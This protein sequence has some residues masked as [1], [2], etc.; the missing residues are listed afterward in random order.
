M[1]PVSNFGHSRTRMDDVEQS[2]HQSEGVENPAELNRFQSVPKI[3]QSS[4]QLAASSQPASVSIG[5]DQ[6]DLGGA[7]TSGPG[8]LFSNRLL[9]Q[10]SSLDSPAHVPRQRRWYEHPGL[11]ENRKVVISSILFLFFGAAALITGCVLEAYPKFEQATLDGVIL[12]V[13]GIILLIPGCYFVF[14]IIMASR[15][16]PG[17]DFQRLTNLAH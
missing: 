6:E 15:G 5:V 17:Y 12:I 1:E 8:S 11:V 9:H 13:V 14:Y 7:S 10:Y 16:K 3:N 2:T 4:Y